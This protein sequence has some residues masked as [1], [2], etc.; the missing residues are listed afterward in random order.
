MA[1]HPP[2]TSL[3]FSSRFFFFFHCI[4]L[5][6]PFFSHLPS[7]TLLSSAPRL[8]PVTAVTLVL[9]LF[10][11]WPSLCCG[12]ALAVPAFSVCAH[13]RTGT[14]RHEEAHAQRE[15][16][17]ITAILHHKCGLDPGAHDVAMETFHFS[18]IAEIVAGMVCE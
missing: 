8:S 5:L 13:M 12:C 17:G 1:L 15:L 14:R 9:Y 6:F 11:I 3:H 7:L 18:P 16:C 4:T 10:H 2:T